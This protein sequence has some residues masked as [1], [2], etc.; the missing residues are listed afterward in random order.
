MTPP[1]EPAVVTAVLLHAARLLP[2]TLLS[3]FLGG[4]LVPPVIRLALALALGAAAWALSGGAPAGALDG[5]ALALA[6]FRELGVGIAFAL[7]ASLPVEAARAA[8]RLVD[9][10]RGATLG[11]LHVAPVRQQ[12]TAVGDLLAHWVVVLA[13]W[14]GGDRLVVRGLLAS[15]AALPAGAGFPA[16]PLEVVALRAAGEL[17]ASALAVAA[18]AAAGILAADLAL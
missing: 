12:E 17:L 2:V 15:F 13:A 9:T 14:A 11:E 8:G 6:G 5:P 18:P 4:P 16:G 3:P 1:V 7:V 10:L